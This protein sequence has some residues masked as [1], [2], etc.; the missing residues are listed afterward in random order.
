MNKRMKKK[1]ELKELCA[2]L[3][4]IKNILIEILIA[5][6]IKNILIETLIEEKKKSTHSEPESCGTNQKR[7]PFGFRHK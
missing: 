5:A 3:A 7:K 6:D 1:N 4:D 2:E